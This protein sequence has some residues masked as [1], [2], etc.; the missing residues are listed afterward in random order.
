M[1]KEGMIRVPAT[2]SGKASQDAVIPDWVRNN[3]TGGPKNK[4]PIRTLQMDY[5]IL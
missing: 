5:N 3:Q 4:F 1:I 2:S